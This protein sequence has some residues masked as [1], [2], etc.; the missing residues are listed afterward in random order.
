MRHYY[1]QTFATVEEN[2]KI[3][4]GTYRDAMNRKGWISLG[5]LQANQNPYIEDE[6]GN[7]YRN[8]YGKNKLF[9][10]A[11]QIREAVEKAKKT[12]ER[13]PFIMDLLDSKQTTALL[14]GDI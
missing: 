13:V 12:N 3:R 2:G 7:V 11:T 10:T 9:Y 6:E 4:I 8:L 1:Y 5:S 14:R